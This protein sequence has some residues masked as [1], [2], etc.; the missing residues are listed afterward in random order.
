MY[1]PFLY[2]SRSPENVLAV[3]EDWI[4]WHA[5]RLACTAPGQVD[6]LYYQDLAQEGRLAVYRLLERE[7]HIWA[8]K[9]LR[10]AI[11]AMYAARRRGRSVF[12]ADPFQRTRV[13]EQISLD[14]MDGWRPESDD[15]KREDVGHDGPWWQDDA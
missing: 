3:L 2:G 9:L 14:V 12:R 1:K 15:D 11:L 13:Y 5:Y 10:L 6:N 4:D 8:P 7:P